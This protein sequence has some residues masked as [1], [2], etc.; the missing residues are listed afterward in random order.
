MSSIFSSQAYAQT[1]YTSIWH[2]WKYI[3]EKYYTEVKKKGKN[4]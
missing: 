2:I 3:L 4:R 1:F